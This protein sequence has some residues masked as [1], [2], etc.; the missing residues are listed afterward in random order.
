[1]QLAGKYVIEAKRKKSGFKFL[2]QALDQGGGSDMI[3]V[4]EDRARRLY[5]MEE[6]TVLDLLRLAGLVSETKIG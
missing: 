5:V 3:V 6:D 4:R 1:M 2:Y